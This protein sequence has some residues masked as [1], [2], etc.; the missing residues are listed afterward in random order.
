MYWTRN[1]GHNTRS[2]PSLAAPHPTEKK[3]RKKESGNNF[4]SFLAFERASSS[5]QTGIAWEESDAYRL[6]MDI[7]SIKEEP[8]L[9]SPKTVRSFF[10]VND[11]GA[12]KSGPN[13]SNQSPRDTSCWE[14]LFHTRKCSYKTDKRKSEEI[15][16]YGYY[17]GIKMMSHSAISCLAKRRVLYSFMISLGSTSAYGTNHIYR[18]LLVHTLVYTFIEN[19]RSLSQID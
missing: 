16:L 10:R 2:S 4:T 7:L 15:Q 17:Q 14:M 8:F 5:E 3:W 9:D 11:G 6:T 19:Y 13:T 1:K 12:P 18:V